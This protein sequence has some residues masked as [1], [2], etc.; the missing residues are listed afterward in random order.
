M[1]FVEIIYK[2]KSS[3]RILKIYS[4]HKEYVS[5]V[6]P[7]VTRVKCVLKI[8]NLAWLSA[9]MGNP[10]SNPIVHHVFENL[11]EWHRMIVLF[12]QVPLLILSVMLN[13]LFLKHYRYLEKTKCVPWPIS[14]LIP[15]CRSWNND[16]EVSGDQTT[17]HCYKGN[18]GF[19]QDIHQHGY[20]SAMGT[21][22]GEPQV[23]QT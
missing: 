12:W 20:H 16:W 6:M 14:S 18:L 10:F 5:W 21:W 23:L 1:N 13:V 19:M 8:P 4:G 3:F 9:V 17:R 2:S 11:Q 7:L 15:C 22:W